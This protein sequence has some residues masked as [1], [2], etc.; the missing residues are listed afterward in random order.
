MS[1]YNFT[2]LKNPGGGFQWSAKTYGVNGT[3]TSFLLDPDGKV[4]FKFNGLESLDALKIC[5]SEVGGL[6]AF[7]AGTSNAASARATAKS[8]R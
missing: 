1:N 7:S 6:L 5:N 3:P 4:L 2:A 8:Q